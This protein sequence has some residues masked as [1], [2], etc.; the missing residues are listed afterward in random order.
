MPIFRDLA[1]KFKDK[2]LVLPIPAN[3][4]ARKDEI[5]GDLRAFEISNDAVLAMSGAKFAFICSGTATMQAALIGTPF[6]LCYKAKPIDIFIARKFVKLKYAGLANI[7]LDFLG[8][9]PLNLELIQEQV[10]CE[11]LLKAYENEIKN[12][13]KFDS[14]SKRLREYLAHGAAKNVANLI[15]FNQL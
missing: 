3:L 10:T 8:E 15:K 2:K 11:N 6:V 7:I 5:Y 4:M 9:K 1:T 13:A 14:V 12:V